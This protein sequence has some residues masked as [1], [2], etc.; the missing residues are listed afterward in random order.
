MQIFIVDKESSKDGTHLSTLN[1]HFFSMEYKYYPIFQTFPEL[2]SL[3]EKC[4]LEDPW[5]LLPIATKSIGNI[6][7]EHA[8]LKN[9]RIQV[10]NVSAH[11]L[12]DIG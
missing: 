9:G 6:F 5:T 1:L 4:A 2:S 8:S 3:F 10:N 7:S 11:I 12:Q